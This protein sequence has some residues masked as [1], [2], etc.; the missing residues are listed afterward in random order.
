MTIIFRED[1]TMPTIDTRSLKDRVDLAD[2]IG[3]YTDLR[4][5][6]REL[7]GPCPF[8]G[9]TDRLLVNGDIWTCR[10]C[11]G[12]DKWHD[13]IAFVEKLKDLPFADACDWLARWANCTLPTST[14]STPAKTRR[15]ARVY[16][17]EAPAQAWREKARVVVTTC[18]DALWSDAG[19]KAREYLHRRGLHDDTLR[20]WDFGFC[21]APNRKGMEI[22]GLYVR[23]GI[24]I[25]WV[26]AGLLWAVN[27]RL[28]KPDPGS[29]EKYKMI[30]GSRK[31]GALFGLD[32]MTGK[33]DVVIVEGE[34]DAM[35]AWQE[36]GDLVD[37]LTL[38]NAQARLSDRWI[39]RLL[40]IKRFWIATDDDKAGWECADYWLGITG[41]RGMRVLPPGGKDVTESWQN[42]ESLGLWAD[43]FLACGR[44]QS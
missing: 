40:H 9:G 30:E 34:F 5:A 39:P 20:A 44:L 13:A 10:Q 38:G 11:L 8:C 29:K 42:G 35:L 4:K 15:Q 43:Y 2:L 3:G 25:P 31:A 37:V 27:V 21:N 7:H 18:A 26:M 24:T 12:T 19:S 14:T 41:A 33:E 6:G 1:T 28:P 32:K 17:P 23:H 22:G 16:C 36:I